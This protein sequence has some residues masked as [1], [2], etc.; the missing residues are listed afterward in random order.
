MSYPL[1]TLPKGVTFK[2]T[3]T[4]KFNNIKQTPQSGRHP[5]A[6]TL[7]QG[8]L[9]DFDINWNYL[10]NNGVTTSN[11]QQYLQEFYEAIGGGFQ[12]FSFDPSQYNLENLTVTHD[13][14]QLKNGFF[15]TGNGVQTVFPLWRSTSALGGG[16]VNL[17]ER[18]Q[19][20]TSMAGIY[21]NG[22][23]ISSGLYTLANFPA[24]V[25]FTTAPAVNATLA[26]AGSYN[27][28]CQFAEDTQ[29]FD[30]FMFQL[31]SLKSL[32]LESVAL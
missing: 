27:Y 20:V 7:Q 24:T 10:K 18:I 3:K 8:T 4:P 13:F 5:A 32:K 23:L 31:W 25:T 19:N 29:D 30:E 11:D 14:T 21:V 1:I 26:W 6:A 9:F 12:F 28:L 17:L 15:G 2:Y 22:T 16:N